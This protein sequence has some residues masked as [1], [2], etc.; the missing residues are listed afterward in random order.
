MNIVPASMPA[1]HSLSDLERLLQ[2][3]T[4]EEHKAGARPTVGYVNGMCNQNRYL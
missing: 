2:G 4:L 1:V 3:Q